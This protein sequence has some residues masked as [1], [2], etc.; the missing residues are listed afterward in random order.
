MTLNYSAHYVLNALPKRV[1]Q[2][3]VN[4]RESKRTVEARQFGEWTVDREKRFR[5][6]WKERYRLFQI[7]LSAPGANYP[8]W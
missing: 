1:T 3:F 7:Y 4:W 5:K 8:G 2:E 6:E